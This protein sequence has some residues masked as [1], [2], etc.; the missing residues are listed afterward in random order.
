MILVSGQ[1]LAFFSVRSYGQAFF[2]ASS[3]FSGLVSQLLG[4]LLLVFSMGSLFQVGFLL[5]LCDDGFGSSFQW[6]TLAATAAGFSMAIH[7]FSWLSPCS[8]R[9]FVTAGSFSLWRFSSC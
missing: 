5:M 3:S 7:G 8:V 9:V 2:Q 6:G 1:L 4:A